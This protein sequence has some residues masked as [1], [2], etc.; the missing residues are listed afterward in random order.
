MNGRRAGHG[1]HLIAQAITIRI[2]LRIDRQST[3]MAH[4]P[5]IGD[6]IVVDVRIEPMQAW[7]Q[8]LMQIGQPIAI[9]IMAAEDRFRAVGLPAI[10][11]FLSQGVGIA[12]GVI[13]RDGMAGSRER[14]GD[15]MGVRQSGERVV[16]GEGQSE[17]FKPIR[18]RIIVR[19]PGLIAPAH[20]GKFPTDGNGP[21]VIVHVRQRTDER[22]G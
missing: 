17:C 16:R 22:G 11:Q 13:R 21:D 6:S 7:G 5:S 12:I 9:G 19:V 15:G 2:T 14:G 10:E 8:P 1:F 18:Q 4:G 3:K 20:E